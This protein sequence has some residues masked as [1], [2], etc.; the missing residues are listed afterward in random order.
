MLKS[1]AVTVLLFLLTAGAAQSGE[2]EVQPVTDGVYAIVGPLEQRSKDN[3]ANN[4]TFGLVVTP[5]GAVVIDPGGSWK[6]AEAVE[7]AI[8]TV[9]DAPV[10]FVINSGGQDHRWLGNGYFA[11]KGAEIIAS[12]A[13][14]A[15]QKDRQSIQFTILDALIGADALEGT[16]PVYA[17]TVFDRQHQFSFGGLTFVVNNAAPAHTPGD[18]YVW[19]PEKSTVF[20]GDIVYV[21][22]LLGV[23][24]FS[25]SKGWL[26]AFAAI[27]ALEPE[28]V[29]PGHGHAT[30][31]AQA[32]AQSYDY[33]VNLR[34]KVR[35]H[36]EGGGDM[37][38]SVDVDQSAF[39]DLKLFE[40]LARRNA[41][42]VFAELEFE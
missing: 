14:V 16:Q 13:A 28:H 40:Q 17:G 3:L 5:E 25:D 24:P 7:K 39:R 22:R 11:A 29:V 19:V 42:A 23:L 27:E 20:T 38:G 26:E 9:T 35:A 10:K 1:F 32:R 21:E 12:E 36:L 4:A 18:S 6:G 34:Q 41:Q 30:T 33:L 8:R 31:L 15:D 2:L 37:I